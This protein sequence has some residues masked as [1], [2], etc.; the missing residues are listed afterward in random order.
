MNQDGYGRATTGISELDRM[1][2]G[3]FLRG[4]TVLIAGNAG[5]GKTTLALQ[6]LVNGATQF[7]ENGIYISFEQM[8]DQIYRDALNFGWNLRQLEQMNKLRIIC[9]SP[10]LMT[11]EGATALLADPIREINPSRIVVDSASHLE[12]FVPEKEIRLEA[13]RLVNYFKTKGLTTLLLSES[14]EISGGALTITGTGISF[15]VDC[16]ILLRYVEIESSMKKAITILKMRGSDHDK[17]LRELEITSQG[18]R[19]AS[20]FSQY[21]GV[22][23]GSPRKS[24]TAEAVSNW[25]TAFRRK[26]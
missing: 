3:G 23:T 12:M 7:G 11:G 9:T 1:L 8:P 17:R 26:P 16:V 22:I 2:S 13:Y 4:D 10:D 6:F 20:P 24:L 21:E 19:L 25:A 15:L 5:T 14:H 18:I